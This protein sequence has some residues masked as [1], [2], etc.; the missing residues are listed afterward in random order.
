MRACICLALDCCDKYELVRKLRLI[1][2]HMHC[3]LAH[4]FFFF[5]RS[6]F[7]KPRRSKTENRMTDRRCIRTH[8]CSRRSA[9]AYL[10]REGYIYPMILSEYITTHILGVCRRQLIYTHVRPCSGV[11]VDDLA[12]IAQL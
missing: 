10:M 6:D 2:Q 8:A 3:L 11:C 9:Q 5:P 7:A 12:R 1:I 4:L